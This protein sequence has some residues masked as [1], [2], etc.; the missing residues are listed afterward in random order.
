MWLYRDEFIIPVVATKLTF[1]VRLAVPL[2]APDVAVTVVV[3]GATVAATPPPLIVATVLDDEIHVAVEVRFCVLPSVNVPVAVNCCVLPTKSD[4]VAGVTAIDTTAGA[5][6]VRVVEP[7]KPP[8]LAEMVVVPWAKLVA[9]PPALTVA[10]AD[11]EELHVALLVK[12]FVVPS[13]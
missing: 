11:A 8:E 9:R 4:A 5:A 13:V 7:L 3:P 1:T 10:T 6:T 12:F 2:I